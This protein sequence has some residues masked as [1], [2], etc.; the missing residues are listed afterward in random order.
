MERDYWQRQTKDAPLFPDLAWSRPENRQQAGKL[1]IVG[2]N[3]HGFA[4]PA[5]AYQ[6]VMK[7]GIGTSRVLL[8]DGLKKTVGRVFEAG[9]YAPS[10]PSGSF[11]QKALDELLLQSNW[12]DATLLA[13]DFGRNAETAILLEKFL[14]KYSGQVTLT[15]DAIDYITSSPL[16]VLH[17]QQ[18][19]LVLSLSQLQRLATAS[20]Y[21]MAISFSMDLLHLVDW[22]HSYTGHYAPYIIVK[23]LEHICVA[24]KGRVSTTKLEIEIPLWRLTTA[25]HAA[26]WWLQNQTKPFEALTNAV[27]PS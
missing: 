20:R 10:T 13:G 8:P 14:E 17:R 3:S 6:E 27:L 15:K 21:P 24:V 25:S 19:L 2:G 16:T 23:H 9:E 5:E 26:V 12:A 18:T 22:L 1:L 4:A 11:S 7:A